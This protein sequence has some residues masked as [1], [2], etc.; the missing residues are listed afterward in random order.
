[1]SFLSFGFAIRLPY[2]YQCFY[3]N[4]FGGDIQ[5]VS[6]QI[7]TP[8]PQHAGNFTSLL[9][10][11]ILCTFPIRLMN[12]TVILLRWIYATEMI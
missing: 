8:P 10:F 3:V 4:F 11:T 6:L 7:L 9:I 5:V 2:F 12:G 1:M